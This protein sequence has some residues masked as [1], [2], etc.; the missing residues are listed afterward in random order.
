MGLGFGTKREGITSVTHA[1]KYLSEVA[2]RL[3]DTHIECLDFRTCIE[4]YDGSKTFFYLDPPYRK[5][6][7]GYSNY[8]LLSD[9]DWKDLKNILSKIKGNFLLSTNDD[10][11]V[12]DLFKEWNVQKL[13]VRVS[14]PNKEK[15][16]RRRE[17][18]IGD[19]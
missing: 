6:R 1:K 7:G 3:Q 19:Y 8:D 12:L 11:F 10:P 17:V 14:L 15:S 9:D 18:L 16:K 2:E 5:T 13:D 4:S